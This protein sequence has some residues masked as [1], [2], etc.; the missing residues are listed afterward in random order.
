MTVGYIRG[1]PDVSWWLGQIHAGEEDRRKKAYQDR[2]DIWRQ[3][4]R[5]E[6]DT[7]ILPV[8]LFFT[9][10]RTFVPRVYFRNPAISI[11][12]AK[13]GMEN[14]VFARILERID[15]KLMRQ[16]RIKR[17]LKKMV[18]DAFMFGTADGKTGFS[19]F[20]LPSPATVDKEDEQGQPNTKAFN[21]NVEYR[22]GIFP[23]MPWFTRVAPGNL[24]V[25]KNLDEFENSRWVAESIMRPVDDVRADRRFKNTKGLKTVAV[26][27][28]SGSV[29]RM[30]QL[31]EIR[32]G[33]TNSVIVIT[34]N[35]NALENK[36]LFFGP[37]EMQFDGFNH[38][39]LIFNNDDERFWGI[40]DSQILEPYQ[41]EI[42]EIRTQMMQH[43]RIAIAKILAKKGSIDPT[44]AEKLV[45]QEV[46]PVIWTN[47]DPDT[48]IKVI[49]AANMPPE[50]IQQ[51]QQVMED[52]RETVGFSRNQFGE[53]KQ[54]SGDV[55]A[56]EAAIVQ[57]AVEIRVDE[58]RDMT[59]DLLTAVI[60]NIHSI[61]FKYWNTEQVVDLV[62]P[63]GAPVWVKTSNELLS[64]G[65]YSVKVDP[66]NT[67]PQTRALREQKAIQTYTLL[68]EN[69]LIVPEKLTKFLLSELHGVAFDDMMRAL[70]T[71]EGGIPQEAIDANQFTGLLQSSLDKSQTPEGQE[72]VKGNAE[73]ALRLLGQGDS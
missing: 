47:G 49:Q 41:L 24:I 15:N 69:P 37:D 42:N 3:Y 56:T 45:S 5:G 14:Q 43:R 12:A 48:N 52:V 57:Q 68:K 53:F 22:T 23:N 58:R 35:K 31:Y 6:W 4:Y 28:A 32:D 72:E 10:I 29:T 64:K 54:K 59:A 25:P 38:F 66:D 8:N 71:P 18:Q 11:G 20:F 51:S 27:D 21:E 63:G 26:K 40:P 73:T 46:A 55:S 61:I 17:E 70:P 16:M 44:E 33:K 39:P 13:P 19:G 65:K 67:L 34:P 30:V 9:L 50:L 60:E 2:W 1:A 62:G 7:G 36:P